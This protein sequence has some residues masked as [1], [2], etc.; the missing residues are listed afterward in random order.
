MA[1]LLLVI[2]D[3][4]LFTERSNCDEYAHPVTSQR[5]VKTAGRSSVWR[6][7][8]PVGDPKNCFFH[9]SVNRLEVSPGFGLDN[10]RNLEMEHVLASNYSQCKTT[11]DRKYLL[12]DNAFV[13][14]MKRSKVDVSSGT[15]GKATRVPRHTLLI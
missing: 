12:P 15:T 9:D 14:P 10:L 11:A 4:S 8:F 2:C 6:N 3:F 5:A 7:Q 13:I 1:F